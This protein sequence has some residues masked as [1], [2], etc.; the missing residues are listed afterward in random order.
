MRNNRN[1]KK[2]GD[3]ADRDQ[4]RDFAIPDDEKVEFHGR[5][6][7]ILPMSFTFERK[8][9]FADTDAAG[10]VYFA[11]YLSICH[12]AYEEALAAAGI[13]L[14][15]FFRNEE[16]V[17]PIARANADY[18]RPL[19]AGD[20]IEI[21]LHAEPRE[22]SFMI[23]Y[24]ISR[25][26]PIKKTAARVRTEHVCI[27]ATTRRRRPLPEPIKTWLNEFKSE[28]VNGTIQEQ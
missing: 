8:I 20:Q 24:E 1:S 3:P 27:D 21:S 28:T 19:A 26:S 18:L 6:P 16:V 11:N 13:D 7:I 23:Q 9:R 12:E 22:D 25:T 5:L 15:N 17:I 10:V 2:T 4:S 14:A